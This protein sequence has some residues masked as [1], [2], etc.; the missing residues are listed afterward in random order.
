MVRSRVERQILECFGGAY[1]TEENKNKI[2]DPILGEAL[3]KNLAKDM[4]LSKL[5]ALLEEFDIADKLDKPSNYGLACDL[6]NDI[7]KI[8]F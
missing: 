4:F 5:A 2:V 7:L 3:A 6:I 8:K 1:C